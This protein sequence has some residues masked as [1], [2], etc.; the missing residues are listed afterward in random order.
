VHAECDPVRGA[1]FFHEKLRAQLLDLGVHDW[2]KL[3]GKSIVEKGTRLARQFEQTLPGI[4]SVQVLREHE[5]DKG[6]L[7]FSQVVFMSLEQLTEFG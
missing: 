4:K 1:R 7:E 6:E 5:R 3:K 2:H